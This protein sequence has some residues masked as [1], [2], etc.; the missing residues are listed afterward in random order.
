WND[1]L[2][3]ELITKEEFDKAKIKLMNGEKA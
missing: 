1:L 3:K 2:E